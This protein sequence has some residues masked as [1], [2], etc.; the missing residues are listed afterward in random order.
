MGVFLF[1]ISLMGGNVRSFFFSIHLE[2]IAAG[3]STLLMAPIAMVIFGLFFSLL[4]YLPFK[5]LMKAIKG[6][7]LSGEYILQ[8]T[9][10]ENKSI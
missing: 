6:I 9:A 5:L 8:P 2:G 1:L 7:Y 10:E 3:T 4:S